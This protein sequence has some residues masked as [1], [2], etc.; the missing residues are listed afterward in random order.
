MK[1]GVEDNES[2]TNRLAGLLVA[3]VLSVC[4]TATIAIETVEEKTFNF[5]IP[6]QRADL[7]LTELA[8]QAE[9]TLIFPFE[10]A[11]QLITNTVVGK[12]TLQ[13]AIAILLDDTGLQP[14]IENDGDMA[15][16]TMVSQASTKV[17]TEGVD[18]MFKKEK[19]S[20]LR[21][22]AAFLFV[23][24]A[25][26]AGAQDVGTITEEQ[27]LEEVIVTGLRQ[28]L[29]LAAEF[30][31]QADNIMSVITADDVGNF[32]DQTLAESLSRLAGVSVQDEEGEGRYITVR[33]LDSDYVQVTINNAQLGSSDSGGDRSVA[34]DVVPGDLF[35]RVEVGKTLFP[36]QDHDSFG[37]KVDLRPLSA[38]RRGEGFSAR[39]TVRE[40]YIELAGA[41]DPNFKAD[42]TNMWETAGGGRAGIALAI[43]YDYRTVHGDQLRS[44]SG[45][46]INWTQ[47][48]EDIP[49][50]PIL[51]IQE[52]DMRMER[53]HRERKGGTLV[54]DWEPNDAF[55]LQVSGIYGELFDNDIRVQQEVEL[56][57]ASDTETLWVEKGYGIFTDVDLERQIFYIPQTE[58]TWAIHTEGDYTFGSEGQSTLSFAVDASENNF[59]MGRYSTRGNWRERDQIVQAWWTKEDA[60]YE[61]LGKG[62]FGGDPNDW[63][64]DLEFG[65][66]PSPEDFEFSQIGIIEEDRFDEIF[67]YNVDYSLDFNLFDTD[68]TMKIGWKQRQRERGFVRGELY[69]GLDCD[70]LEPEG[71]P[72]TLAEVPDTFVPDT[73]FDIDGGIP[74]GVIYPVLGWN[75]QFQADIID[76]FGVEPTD[77]R[78]DYEASEDTDALYFMFD[79]DLTDRLHM[80]VGARYEETDYI[81]RGLTDSEIEVEV[82]DPDNPGETTSLTLLSTSDVTPYH[83]TY[84][85]WLP[86]VFFRYDMSDELVM[87]FSY[88][89]GQVRPSYG[90]ANG[91]IDNEWEFTAR[92]ADLDGECSAY[93]NVTLAGQPFEVCSGEGEY[94]IQTDG[95]NPYLDPMIAAQWDWNIGWYPNDYSNLTVSVY[96]KDITDFIMGIG[97]SDPDTIIQLGGNAIDP[98]TGLPTTD[99]DKD[100]NIGDAEMYGLEISGRYGFVNASGWFSNV[101]IAGNAA[102]LNGSTRSEFI[103]DGKD[104]DLPKLADFVGNLS[105]AYEDDK[106][107]FQ[108]SAR[109][110]SNRLNSF[111]S[112]EPHKVVYDDSDLRI[113]VSSYYDF[114]DRIRLF[115]N[116]SNLTDEAGV[117]YFA[118]DERS[119]QLVNR[120]A[121]FG[122][123]WRVGMDFRF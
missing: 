77:V 7:A 29:Q 34:L 3:F 93:T 20:F 15:I 52:L 43:S 65:V 76:I 94:D 102:F 118:G 1:R 107:N 32:P 59:V 36:D 24:G 9:V 33:G 119:G 53:G 44:T 82:L 86:G 16:V 71:L 89:T 39:A 104:I 48:W 51:A 98:L 8:A 63:Y 81:A 31:R 46:G 75:R 4:S 27:V 50:P 68:V 117:R 42:I 13:D 87:R 108:I 74:E 79:F 84:N 66:Y 38:F 56:R 78:R 61:V 83:H 69:P 109:Y 115:A 122:R 54:F 30:E 45:G 116:V 49:E 55:R 96:Y 90:A 91:L 58:E 5:N 12:Y 111:D 22:L 110:R 35:Q 6:Q 95:G 99:F 72:C 88:S 11:R 62:D 60:W 113:G 10:E 57:D 41:W 106:F 25:A 123:T 14:Q 70:D 105:L 21:K 19:R 80:V 2:K 17:T 64:E 18:I 114:N 73:E 40:Q 121:E 100:I 112:D 67:S 23:G 101:F 28:Q 92:E 85:N 120:R 47:N 26:T 103:A 97:T 37:A